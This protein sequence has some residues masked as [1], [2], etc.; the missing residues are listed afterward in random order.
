MEYQNT[1]EGIFRERPNRFLAR[2]EVEG[3]EEFC[4]VKNTGRCREL[5]QPGVRVILERHP[6]GRRKTRF[7]LVTVEK[8]G[9]WVNIDSQAPNVAAEE[10]LWTSPLGWPVRLVRRETF[11]EDSRFDF[12]LEGEGERRAFLEVKGVTLEEGGVARFPDAPTERGVRHVHHLIRAVEAGYEA[13]LLFVIQMKGV[14]RWEP[15]WQTHPAFGEAVREAAAAGVQVLARD[16]RVWPEGMALDA[17]VPCR[18]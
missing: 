8:Q 7:S 13:Y 12:Y 3:S 6:P 14:V 4:H 11:F 9:R 15:N 16:C 18:Y 2:V 17:P 10:W 5:L 1:V